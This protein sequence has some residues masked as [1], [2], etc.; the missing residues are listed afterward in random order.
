MHVHHVL[1]HDLSYICSDFFFFPQKTTFSYI[2]Q[3]VRDKIKN[4]PVPLRCLS[5]GSWYGTRACQNAYHTLSVTFKQLSVLGMYC[6]V[7]QNVD[8]A[9][10][11]HLLSLMSL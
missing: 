1:A 6:S 9:I 4:G 2:A 10:I 11:G 7:T 8:S 3:A 5:S